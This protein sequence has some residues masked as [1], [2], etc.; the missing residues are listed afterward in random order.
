VRRASLAI[1]VLALAVAGVGCPC[2]RGAV[3]ASPEVRWWLLSSFGASRICPEMLKRGVP[4]KLHELGPASVGRFFPATCDVQVDDA[5][6][7]I[8]TTVTGSGYLVLPVARRVGFSV[9][10]SVEYRP[11][12]RLEPDATYVWGEL[13]RFVAPPDLRILG[14]ENTLVNLA[15][16]TPL[17]TVATVIGNAL[18]ASEIGRGFTVV[19]REDGDDFALG[20]LEAPETPPRAFAPGGG[21]TLLASDVTRVAARERE[22]LGPFEVAASGAALYLHARTTGAPLTYSV[23]ERSVG[24][25]WRREYEGAQPLAPPPGVLAVQGQLGLG[26]AELSFPLNP[27]VYYVVLENPAPPTLLA[28]PVAEVAYTVAVGARR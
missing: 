8:V 24:E 5:R 7:V 10:M 3:N 20:H 25:R 11:D 2:A 6:K 16:R 18:V 14:V 15:T 9:G 21:Q 28:E 12:F 13:S 27:G 22:Y 1:V 4:L 26:E 19:R 23:A 17:G